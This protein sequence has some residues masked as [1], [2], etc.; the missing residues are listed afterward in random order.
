VAD[1]THLRTFVTVHRTGSLTEAANLL[2]IS[3][4][5]VSAHIQALEASFGFALFVRGRSGTSPTAKGSEL[6]RNVAG[7]IDALDDIAALSAVESTESRAL[8]LGGPAELLSVTVVP[9]L[10]EIR[11]AV[12]APLRL[13][14]GLADDLLESLRTGALDVV[15][16]AVRPRIAGIAA[17]P[18]YD[19]E[20]VL[21]GAPEWAR[22][23]P[24]D[25]ST[26][27]VV[28]YAENLPIIRRY[29]RS[30]FRRRPDELR[31]TAVIPDLRGVRI[32]VLAGL[33]MSVL[34]EY[35]VA[36]DLASGALV[37]LH[38]PPVAPLNTGYLAT[39]SGDLARSP[40]LRVLAEELRRLIG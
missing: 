16:S 33:G 7:H 35:L 3:Q 21:V 4:P 31:T 1:L 40:R 38:A 22:E 19:E 6:A 34:P 27:P 12:D 2:G 17:T 11:T 23:R 5:T 8:H 39:R 20:F 28:A 9:A 10:G 24:A 13:T 18:L 36:D 25:W 37:P 26:I 29:W 15:V 32:A 14:F 30:V